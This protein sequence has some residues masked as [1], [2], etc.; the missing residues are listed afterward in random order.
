[1]CG[2]LALLQPHSNFQKALNLLKSRGPDCTKILEIDSL[3]FGFQRLKINDLVSGMQPF[4]I[5][6]IVLICNGEIYNHKQL[7]TIWFPL[8]KKYQSESD[9]EIIIHLYKLIGIEQTLN[10]LDGVFAFVLYDKSKDLLFVCRDRIGVRPLYISDNIAF[11]SEAK[12]L[13]L[14][15][16]KNIHQ[17]R[18]GSF[19]RINLFSKITQRFTYWHIPTLPKQLTHYM[20]L[21]TRQSDI[22][23]TLKSLLTKAVEKR[24]MS[25]RPI[26]CLLSGGLDS[27][28]IAAI[29][30]QYH[31]VNTYSIGF[32]N[33]PDLLAARKVAKY[34]KSNHHEV[35]ITQ[36]E[37]LAAIPDVIYA[38]ESY[39]IT[40]VRASVPMYLLC[41]HIKQNY[42]DTVIFSGEGSD[43]LLCGYLY[44]HLAKDGQTTFDESRRLLHDIHLYDVLRADRSTAS[45]GLE[46]RV[47]FLDKD[48]V[49]FCMTLDG[50]SRKPYKTSHDQLNTKF[51][52]Y[53]LRKAFEDMLPDEIAWR[54]KDGMSDGISHKEKPWYSIIQ[55][56]ALKKNLTEKLPPSF[57][58]PHTTEALY[59]YLEFKKHFTHTPITY[60]W[61]PKWSTNNDPS[62]RLIL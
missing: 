29:L 22:C 21:E 52:K 1:M 47:P 34:L 40:T 46:L 19:I 49:N 18:P 4:D 44:F 43:E 35:V 10:L 20:S 30:S 27:S 62:G 28:I 54:R 55:D 5:D 50:D 33:S 51:E 16:M 7:K 39:D 41:K 14:L 57:P 9:C 31:T 32:E 48:V 58:Q 17:L 53:Y 2:I 45:N 26:G 13:E 61:M 60:H 12:A 23:Q 37:A 8:D 25:D 59:Y 38:I 42:P 6:N 24:L 56:F 15:K 11:S 3:Q 36:Q